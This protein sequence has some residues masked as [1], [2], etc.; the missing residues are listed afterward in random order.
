MA[1]I[2]RRE[3]KHDEFVDSVD[4]LRLYLEEHGRRVGLL[5]ALVVLVAVSIGAYVWYTRAQE[6]KAN[7]LLSQ[8]VVSFEAP[9]QEGLPPLPGQEG[10]IFSSQEEKWRTVAGKFAAVHEEH[11]RTKA[12]LIAKHYEG[13]CKFRLGEQ[14]AALALLEEVAGARDREVASLAKL[15]LAG[16]YIEVDRAEEAEELYRELIDS[17]TATVPKPAAQMDLAALLTLSDP[18]EARDLYEQVKTEFP[19]TNIAALAGQRQELL[20]ETAPEE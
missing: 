9:V 11:P 12:G 16:L 5:A 14:D 20:P 1:R 8:A 7:I 13:I 4:N 15:H 18:A 19:D 2:Q 17:P 10:R 3:L 6:E